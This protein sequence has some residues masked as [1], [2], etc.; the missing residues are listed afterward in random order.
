M[1]WW[2]VSLYI[3]WWLWV[4][5]E[6]GIKMI[7]IVH[8]ANSLLSEQYP[9]TIRLWWRQLVDGGVLN[10]GQKRNAPFP[11]THSWWTPHHNEKLRQYSRRGGQAFVSIGAI[12]RRTVRNFPVAMIDHTSFTELRTERNLIPTYFT[13]PIFFPMGNL[14]TLSTFKGHSSNARMTG[15]IKPVIAS[16]P[17]PSS[18]WIAL[19]QRS[20]SRLRRQLKVTS[21]LPKNVKW[22]KA[23]TKSQT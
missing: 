5:L 9:R 10:P 17:L 8:N 14:H 6:C 1:L 4:K 21:K 11:T 13:V 23:Y 16:L 18:P 7:K 22:S 20:P 19:F 3:P 12:R 2:R 15:I